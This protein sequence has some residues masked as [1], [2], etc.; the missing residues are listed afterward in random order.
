MKKLNYI[1]D[2][3]QNCNKKIIYLVGNKLDLI[4]NREII[5]NEARDLGTKYNAKYL[6][7]SAK[8]GLNIDNL[9]EYILQDIIQRDKVE[10]IQNNNIYKKNSIYRNDKNAK[11]NNF[12]ENINKN[13]RFNENENGTNYDTST[14]FLKTKD[15]INTTNY[16][17]NFQGIQ[18]NENKD[19]SYYY[20][21][22]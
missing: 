1:Y 10:T 15:F 14:N 2:L 19:K 17:M 9:F 7:V 21:N 3:K 11:N 20:K 8:N 5:E 6:E 4:N 16:N 13:E 18:N 12:L 22:T